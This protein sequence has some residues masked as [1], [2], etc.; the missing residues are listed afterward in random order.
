MHE[1]H[2]LMK[3]QSAVFTQ[4]RFT[5]NHI[6]MWC[7]NNLFSTAKTASQWNACFTTSSWDNCQCTI[8]KYLWEGF[9]TIQQTNEIKL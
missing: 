5:A 8:F 7:H 4:S 6:K 2:N 9:Y 3:E 1:M